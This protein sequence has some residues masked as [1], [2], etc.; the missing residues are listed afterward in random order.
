MNCRP[1]FEYRRIVVNTRQT[2]STHGTCSD[3][4]SNEENEGE[5]VRKDHFF[6]EVT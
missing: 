5:K 3:I 2:F 4:L 1:H 6:F